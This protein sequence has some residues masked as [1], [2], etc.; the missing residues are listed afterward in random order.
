MPDDDATTERWM[1]AAGNLAETRAHLAAIDATNAAAAVSLAALVAEVTAMR[2]RDAVNAALV[3][4]S[5][6][7]GAKKLGHWKTAFLVFGGLVSLITTAI[8][9]IQAV[10]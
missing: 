10:R 9:V 4:A 5:A 3:A 6:R 7:A 2:E 8:A 1:T